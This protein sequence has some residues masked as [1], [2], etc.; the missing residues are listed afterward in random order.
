[1]SCGLG[2]NSENITSSPAIKNSTPNKPTPPKLSVICLAIDLALLSW[3][4]LRLAGCQL[5][6]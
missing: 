4:I 3:S 2:D 1:M 6:W 5:D